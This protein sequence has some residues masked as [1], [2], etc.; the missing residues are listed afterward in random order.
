MKIRAINTISRSYQTKQTNFSGLWGD[1]I[2][3][4]EQ[5]T[6][7]RQTDIYDCEI[8]QYYPFAEEPLQK[9]HDI[10]KKNTTYRTFESMNSALEKL[11]CY[12]HTGTDVRVK[13]GLLFTTKQWLNYLSKKIEAGTPEFNLIENNL[14][15]L[16]LE[17]YLRA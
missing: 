15:N 14:K 13:K 17:R 2:K 1:T 5:L 10:M 8:K 9:V 4:K 3:L 7:K 12:V 6:S 16:H 11:P